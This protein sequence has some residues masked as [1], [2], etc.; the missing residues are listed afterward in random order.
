MFSIGPKVKKFLKHNE[1]L[2]NTSYKIYFYIVF[3]LFF[4]LLL[5]FNILKKEKKFNLY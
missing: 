3:L 4:N 2:V 1:Q 5:K